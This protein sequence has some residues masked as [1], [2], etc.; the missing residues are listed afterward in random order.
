MAALATAAAQLRALERQRQEA[1]HFLSHDLRAPLSATLALIELQD[2][3]QRTHPLPE[4]E[5]QTRR[6]LALADGFVQLARAESVQGYRMAPLDLRD[7]VVEAADACWP[8]AQA[9]QVALSSETPE[10]ECLVSADRGMLMRALVNLIDNALKHGSRPGTGVQC[11]LLVGGPGW[12]IEVTDAGA[13]LP[14]DAAAGLFGRFR[15]GQADAAGAGL[16]LAFVQAV[17]QHHGGRAGWR[18]GTPGNVFFIE[19]PAA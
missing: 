6:A 10:H 4:I 19:L 12:C 18:A 8:Q 7:V 9:A 17:A 16:G 2:A 11:R 3:A 5:A 14:P 1:L 15:R 13:P